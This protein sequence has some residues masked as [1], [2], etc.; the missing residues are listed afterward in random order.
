VELKSA[1]ADAPADELRAKVENLQRARKTLTRLAGFTPVLAID[2]LN[3]A[4]DQ[5]VQ[6][7]GQVTGKTLGPAVEKISATGAKLEQVYSQ[8]SDSGCAAK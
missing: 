3:S 1:S 7:T 4:V 8:V 5:V 6:A 2:E